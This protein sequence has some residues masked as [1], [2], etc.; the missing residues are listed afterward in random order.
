MMKKGLVSLV[1][2]FAVFMAFGY[3]VSNAGVDSPCLCPKGYG[4]LIVE[5]VVCVAHSLDVSPCPEGSSY[6]GALAMCF[7]VSGEEGT[8]PE[9]MD[10]ASFSDLCLGVPKVGS[11][12]PPGGFPDLEIGLCRAECI[13]SDASAGVR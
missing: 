12:C 13:T 6:N 8:C 9:G 4:R 5:T 7:A 2:L 3:G 10:K 11:Q 1:L